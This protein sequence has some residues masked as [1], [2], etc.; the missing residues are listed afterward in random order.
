MM[1][2]LDVLCAR[3]EARIEPSEST[4]AI[5]TIANNDSMCLVLSS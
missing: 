2:V 1:C 5:S 3:D 4:A